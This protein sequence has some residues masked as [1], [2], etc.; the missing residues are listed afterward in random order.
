MSS[1][2]LFTRLTPLQFNETENVPPPVLRRERTEDYIHPDRRQFFSEQ[3][4]THPFSAQDTI[5]LS[6]LPPVLRRETPEDYLTPLPA[7]PR[8][9]RTHRTP[10]AERRVL[11]DIYNIRPRRLVFN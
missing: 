8:V 2:A 10:I 6:P 1:S 9:I 4:I 7:T 5:T 3:T 11:R